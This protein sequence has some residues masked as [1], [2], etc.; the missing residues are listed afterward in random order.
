MPSRYRPPRSLREA[1]AILPN[2]LEI[3]ALWFE[4]LYSPWLATDDG[5]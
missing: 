2:E 1:P 3:Q 4:Q 5:R